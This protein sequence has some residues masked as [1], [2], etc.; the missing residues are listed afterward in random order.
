MSV[1]VVTV[2]ISDPS[3]LSWESRLTIRQKV[4]TAI[5]WCRNTDRYDDPVAV[6][7]IP[8]ADHA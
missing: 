7:L 4:A 1:P 2:R 6:D 5:R 3:A 8:E